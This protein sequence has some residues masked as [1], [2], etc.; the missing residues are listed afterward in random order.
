[1]ATPQESTGAGLL[2]RFE[3][4]RENLIGNS[5]FQHRTTT[6]VDKGYS[7]I[8][9]GTWVIETMD[10]DDGTAVFLQRIDKDGGV[11]LALPNSVVKAIYSHHGANVK[12][13]KSFRAIK[14]TETRKR[15]GQIP[16]AKKNEK[17]E[18][19]NE[20]TP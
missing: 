19:G 18:P 12:K 3:R 14:A 15:K 11:R 20:V 7:L 1:M 13:R 8:P 9:S 17:P 6:I 10:T 2:D 16:F 5:G 4:A